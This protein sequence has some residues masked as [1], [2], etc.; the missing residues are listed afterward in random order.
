MVNLLNLDQVGCEK[1]AKLVFK[2]ASEIMNSIYS[3]RCWV[4]S[5]TMNHYKVQYEQAENCTEIVLSEA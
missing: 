1:F 2:K 5:L 4:E 3:D